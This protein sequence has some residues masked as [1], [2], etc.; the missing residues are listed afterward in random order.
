MHPEKKKTVRRVRRKTILPRKL[1]RRGQYGLGVVLDRRWCILHGL[2]PGD[3][4]NL[5]WHSSRKD[6]LLVQANKVKK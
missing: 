3:T 6:I 1:S 2:E 4:V 5:F